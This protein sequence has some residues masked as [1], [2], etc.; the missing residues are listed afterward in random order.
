[1]N[2]SFSLKSK[3]LK[4]A[5]TNAHKTDG[6]NETGPFSSIGMTLFPTPSGVNINNTDKIFK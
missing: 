6:S 2:T 4:T 1:M 3:F 5:I